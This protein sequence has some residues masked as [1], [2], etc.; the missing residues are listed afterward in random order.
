MLRDVWRLWL[1]PSA[2]GTVRWEPL[3]VRVAD[4]ADA[5]QG[6]DKPAERYGHTAVAFGDRAFVYGGVRES[7]R[8]REG[9]QTSRFGVSSDM[10][11]VN[12][13][14]GEW[15]A[16]KA[17][18]PPRGRAFHTA[19]AVGE[20]MLVFGGVDAQG[21]TLNDLWALHVST[22]LGTQ[23]AELRPLSDSRMRLFLGRSRHT[24]VPLFGSTNLL[25]YGGLSGSG[26]RRNGIRVLALQLALNEDTPL[27]LYSAVFRGIPCTRSPCLHAVLRKTL[28]DTVLPPRSWRLPTVGLALPSTHPWRRRGRS[29]S[30]ASRLRTAPP[31]RRPRSPRMGRR[32]A[33][34]QRGRGG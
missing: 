28:H 17:A 27:P 1:P 4:R 18:V 10:W 13:A 26:K 12:A 24:A 7:A 31:R 33:A 8:A 5:V 32:A 34:S 16:V 2:D 29:R 21:E 23:W 25:L 22:V 9:D 6:D 20:A 19:T 15:R 30:S 11:E 14:T 3:A